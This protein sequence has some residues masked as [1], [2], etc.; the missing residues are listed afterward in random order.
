MFTLLLSWTL[1][2][3]F[4]NCGNPIAGFY[5]IATQNIYVCEWEP[6]FTYEHEK[7]HKIWFT[8]LTE[9]QKKEYEQ[10][11]NKRKILFRAYA[12][13]VIEDFADSYAHYI[14]KT[15]LNIDLRK[16]VKLVEKF[17]NH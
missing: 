16:R 9:E 1:L 2:Y 13:N 10:A 8:Q 12:K 15:K 3:S 11:F 14:L 4:Y 5:D 17:L 6:Q 7:G